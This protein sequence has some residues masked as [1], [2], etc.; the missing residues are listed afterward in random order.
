MGSEPGR[1]SESLV[2]TKAGKDDIVEGGG[3]GKER[4]WE[5]EERETHRDSRERKRDRIS[6][7]L[8]TRRDFD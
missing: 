8:S 3:G 6:L 4:S 2:K 1:T 7:I 5:G